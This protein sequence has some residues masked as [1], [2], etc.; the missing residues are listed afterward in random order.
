MKKTL[1]ILALLLFMSSQLFSQDTTNGK[2]TTKKFEMQKSPTGAIIRSLIL[3]GWGQYYVE[4]YW[5][6]PLFLGAAGTCAYFII[7]NNNKFKAKQTEIDKLSAIDPTN[8]KI[9]FLKKQREVYRDNRD[10]SA[11]FLAGV[12]LLATID[13]YVGAHLFDFNVNDNLSLN[14]TPKQG[15]VALNFTYYF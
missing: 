9:S 5:K 12:Y 10:Q 1:F 11:F 4:S 3:P 13:S 2:K 8:Y 15:I 14:L 6:A 7:D